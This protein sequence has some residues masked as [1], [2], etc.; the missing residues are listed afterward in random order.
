MLREFF[1]FFSIRSFWKVFERNQSDLLTVFVHCFL[2]FLLYEEHLMVNTIRNSALVQ[3]ISPDS[4]THIGPDIANDLR[5]SRYDFPI[6]CLH[7]T[8]LFSVCSS[9]FK[10][11]LWFEVYLAAIF[12]KLSCPVMAFAL[13]RVSWSIYGPNLQGSL[14][15]L[16]VNQS[17]ED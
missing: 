11:V 5:H 13:V 2:L 14:T 16:R 8:K 6:F 9:I 10:M 15:G 7:N 4:H 12:R 1:F 17:E 3:L